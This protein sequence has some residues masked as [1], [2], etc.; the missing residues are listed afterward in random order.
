MALARIRRPEGLRHVTP[1]ELGK[2][3]A[4]DRVPRVRTPREK[5]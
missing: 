4:L 3:V 2:T 5:L 1:G